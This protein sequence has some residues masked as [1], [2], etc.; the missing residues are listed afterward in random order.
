MEI[1]RARVLIAR[2]A[3]DEAGRWASER[4]RRRQHGN[5][6]PTAPLAFMYDLEDLSIAR[7]LLAR[8][9]ADAAMALMEPLAQRAEDTGQW[10]NLMEARMLLA[11]ARWL[12]GATNAATCM[13]HSAL[14]IAAPEGFVRV[15]LDEG[16]VM[17]DLLA[18]YLANQPTPS[19]TASARERE[20]ARGLLAA[21]GRTVAA[22]TSD[23][24]LD[25]LSP[26]EADVLRLLATGR[27]NEEIAGDLVLALSTVKWHVAHIYRKLGVR[28][29][30]QAVARA[31]ELRLIA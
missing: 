22:P 17:A 28:G 19:A 9:D 18:H 16:E 12:A 21:F 8:G 14:T 15:F 26:R 7:V 23:N 10:R 25:V 27:S 24:P 30:M 31:R 13:L 29:R 20:H 6:V 3:L 5:R 11:Q 2:G 4:L 1:I